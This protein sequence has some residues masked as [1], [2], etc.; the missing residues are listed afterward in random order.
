MEKKY[1]YLGEIFLIDDSKGCYIEV[2][3]KDQTGYLG[4]AYRGTEDM[5]YR[6]SDTRPDD[7]GYLRS[8]NSSGKDREEHLQNLCSAL[9]HWHREAESRKV[10]DSA[11][12]C[13]ALHEFVR[14][15]P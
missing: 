4:L 1:D 13:D 10:F 14:K 12:A 15:L 5:P 7:Q 11:K 3:Y 2:T 6:W 9:L 8:G